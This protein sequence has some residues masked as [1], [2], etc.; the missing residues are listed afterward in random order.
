MYFFFFLKQ[1]REFTQN[2]GEKT[3]LHLEQANMQTSLPMGIKPRSLCC[4]TTLP[5]NWATTS[6]P[7]PVQSAYL[8]LP[9]VDLEDEI[10]LPVVVT[11]S[12]ARI[13]ILSGILINCMKM[14]FR[15]SRIQNN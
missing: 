13:V 3:G 11:S 10:T 6:P 4:E 2:L 14:L 1:Y 8:A 12:R 5:S 15:G 9:K 7:G